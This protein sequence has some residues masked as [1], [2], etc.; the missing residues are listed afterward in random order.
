LATNISA[1]GGTGV[2]SKGRFVVATPQRPV[3]GRAGEAARRPAAV[4]AQQHPHGPEL[5][6]GAQRLTCGTCKLSVVHE[7]TGGFQSGAW[8]AAYARYL[9]KWGD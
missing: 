4:R 8:E 9:E 2:M 7:N 6:R 3:H 1:L 5:R